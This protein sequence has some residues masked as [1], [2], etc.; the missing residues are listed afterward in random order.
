LHEDVVKRRED[1]KD[2]LK[3]SQSVIQGDP[4]VSSQLIEQLQKR[5]LESSEYL[6]RDMLALD[7]LA[8][9]TPEQ[10]AKRKEQQY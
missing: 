8:A 6:M 2:L 4:N 3:A 10:K 9:S 7:F 5:C 1:V